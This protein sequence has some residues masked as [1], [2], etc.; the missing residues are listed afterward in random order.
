V[1]EVEMEGFLRRFNKDKMNG[2]ISL[3]EFMDE[4]TPKAPG[5]PF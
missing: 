5:K 4:L 3:P 1:E 2:R